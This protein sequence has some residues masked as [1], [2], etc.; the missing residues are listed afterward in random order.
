MD[1]CCSQVCCQPYLKESARLSETTPHSSLGMARVLVVSE[2]RA[3]FE[4]RSEALAVTLSMGL[5]KTVV[6][7][8]AAAVIDGQVGPSGLR[9]LR[10]AM[11]ATV[12]RSHGVACA[13]AACCAMR[14]VAA[15]QRQLPWPP[16]YGAATVWRLRLLRGVCHAPV[17]SQ[18]GAPHKEPRACCQC[19]VP[20]RWSVC[21][22]G[23]RCCC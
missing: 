17:S 20:G 1:V 5:L 8:A 15:A 14:A 13:V 19:I 3:G 2:Q 9:L 10:G 11:A 4:D 18:R 22:G 21:R 23:V 7:V 12:W 6:V 16:P